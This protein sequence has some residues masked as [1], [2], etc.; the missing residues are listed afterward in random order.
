MLDEGNSPISLRKRLA[1]S[2]HVL[3]MRHVQCRGRLIQEYHRSVLRDDSSQ[4]GSQAFA[5]GQRR[6]DSVFPPVE[7]DGRYRIAHGLAVALI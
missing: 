6:H 1:Q 4:V 5:S 3:L 7:L 2:Q